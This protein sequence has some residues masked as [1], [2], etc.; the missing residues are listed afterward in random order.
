MRLHYLL[1]T[2][3]YAKV[4]PQ[5]SRISLMLSYNITKIFRNLL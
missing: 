2:E 4:D 3:C 1:L 5:G